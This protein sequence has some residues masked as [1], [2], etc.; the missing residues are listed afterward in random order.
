[1]LLS[2]CSL[3]PLPINVSLY[4][5]GCIASILYLVLLFFLYLCLHLMMPLLLKVGVFLLL[6]SPLNTSCTSFLPCSVYNII[7]PIMPL[8]GP[9]LPLPFS[10]CWHSLIPLPVFPLYFC[11]YPSI[12]FLVPLNSST[13]APSIP[14]SEPSVSTNCLF[15]TRQVSKSCSNDFNCFCIS[16]SDFHL[17]LNFSLFFSGHTKV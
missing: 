17:S 6:V 3:H 11:L 14:L 8:P 13:H 15:H 12:S 5:S 4:T 9:S 7:C 16:Q 10:V 1:M 2:V